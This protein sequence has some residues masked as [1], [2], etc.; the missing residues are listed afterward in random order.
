MCAGITRGRVLN[1]ELHAQI[2]Q[3]LIYLHLFT[4]CHMQISPQPPEKHSIVGLYICMY[5]LLI[6]LYNSMKKPREG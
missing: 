3:K 4:D 1:G 5:Y 6:Q 2:F